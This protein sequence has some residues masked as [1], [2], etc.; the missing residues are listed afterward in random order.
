MKPTPIP[1]LSSVSNVLGAPI[2]CSVPELQMRGQRLCP[3]LVKQERSLH[4]CLHICHN[5]MFHQYLTGTFTGGAVYSWEMN[6][7]T[8]TEAT[9]TTHRGSCVLKA[10]SGHIWKE[11]EARRYRTVMKTSA[12]RCQKVPRKFWGHGV[13]IPVS[14]LLLELLPSGKWEAIFSFNKRGRAKTADLIND[15]WRST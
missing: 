10:S 11:G 14:P 1:N 12:P 2:I 4:I 6:Y 8:V 5:F 3:S 15:A 9:G 13:A 7:S